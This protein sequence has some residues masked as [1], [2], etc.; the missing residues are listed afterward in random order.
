MLPVLRG[1]LPHTF[2]LKR[3][4]YRSDENLWAI[5]ECLLTRVGSVV[6]SLRGEGIHDLI[7]TKEID[8]L[9]DTIKFWKEFNFSDYD[10]ST[11]LQ[12][13]LRYLK[14]N[15]SIGIFIR[16]QNCFM[17]FKKLKE[18]DCLRLMTFRASLPNKYVM[19]QSGCM[20]ISYP[21]TVNIIPASELLLSKCF[22]RQL[23]SL[24]KETCDI[25]VIKTPK[26][27]ELQKEVREPSHPWMVSEFLVEILNPVQNPGEQLKEEVTITKKFRDQVNTGSGT[28]IPWRRSGVWT[29]VKVWL[30]MS[31]HEMASDKAEGKLLYKLVLLRFLTF[32]GEDYLHI[33]TNPEWDIT[34]E[35]LVKLARRAT[36]IQR[37]MTPPMKL[38]KLS[39]NVLE[40][41][42][43]T[44]SM[45][46]GKIS[47]AWQSTCDRA[48]LRLGMTP[49]TPATTELLE[50]CLH[51][52]PSVTEHL[53]KTQQLCSTFTSSFNGHISSFIVEVPSEI[54]LSA[55]LSC[56]ETLQR[57]K[58]FS[59][60]LQDPHLNRKSVWIYQVERFARQL[61]NTSGHPSKNIFDLLLQYSS[62]TVPLFEKE[63]QDPV[64][65]SRVILTLLLFIQYLDK[66]A[67]NNHPLLSEFATGINP[68]YFDRLL[69]PEQSEMEIL[70]RLK[71]YFVRRNGIG[72]RSWLENSDVRS[73]DFS[74]RYVNT[75]PT[76]QK[77]KHEMLDKMEHDIER[78]YAEVQAA[79]KEYKELG[80]KMQHELDGRTLHK[81]SCRRGQIPK[82]V[83][84]YIKILPEQDFQQNAVVF[85]LNIPETL[86]Y[87]RDSVVLFWEEILGQKLLQPE[88]SNLDHKWVEYEGVTQFRG[89]SVQRFAHLG[90]SQKAFGQT[91]YGKNIDVTGYDVRPENF[92]VG[93][94][95]QTTLFTCRHFQ[96]WKPE[97]ENMFTM[98]VASTG[99]KQGLYQPLQFALNLKRPSEN[100]VIASQY[101]CHHE[102][103]LREF[104]DF[105]SLRSGPSIQ[106][107]NLYIAISSK[108]LSLELEPVL[109][110][111]MQT[112]W[113]NG[114]IDQNIHL[115]FQEDDKFSLNFL[116]LVERV[117]ED[118]AS[119]WSKAMM[120][121]PLILIIVRILELNPNMNREARWRLQRFRIKLNSW[122][123]ALEDMLRREH[124]SDG[125]RER[126]LIS[127]LQVSVCL[128]FTFNVASKDLFEFVMENDDDVVTYLRTL[129]RLH[130]LIT[131]ENLHRNT[132]L[133]NFFQNLLRQARCTIPLNLKSHLHK[134]LI[135]SGGS[136]LHKFCG[137][138]W[139]GA[140]SFKEGNCWTQW[141]PLPN[142]SNHLFQTTQPDGH[143]LSVDILRGTFLVNG[144]PPS[145]LPEN[146]TG[147]PLFKSFFESNTFR[148]QRESSG[149]F[150]T[151]DRYHGLHYE[152]MKNATTLIIRQL[153]EHDGENHSSSSG[154]ME[155]VPRELFQGN[156][157]FDLI[158]NYTH[159]F[160]SDTKCIHFVTSKLY[161]DKEAKVD[162]KLVP[163]SPVRPSKFKLMKVRSSGEISQ[164]CLLSINST[165]F[166]L[167]AMEIS[168]LESHDF[169]HVTLNT[170]TDRLTINLW[171]H[172]LD[173]TINSSDGLLYSNKFPGYHIPDVNKKSRLGALI[174]LNNYLLMEKNIAEKLSDEVSRLVLVPHG[175]VVISSHEDKRHQNVTI[176]TNPRDSDN[177]GKLRQPTFFTFEV[178]TLLQRLKPCN[179]TSAWLYLA[180]LHGATSSPLPDPFTGLTGLESAMWIL[181]SGMVWSCSPY[182]QECLETLQFISGLSPKYNYYPDYLSGMQVTTWPAGLKK[183]SY[184]AYDGYYIIVEKLLEDSCR[185][186]D[187]YPEK[188]I[189]TAKLFE[190]RKELLNRSYLRHINMYHPVARLS[191]LFT[192]AP[193]HVM[194]PLPPLKFS[195]SVASLKMLAG[196]RH[197]MRPV[198]LPDLEKVSTL[199]LTAEAFKL[200]TREESDSILQDALPQWLEADFRPNWFLLYDLSLLSPAKCHHLTFLLGALL[201]SGKANMDQILN[202]HNCSVLEATPPSPMLETD[203]EKSFFPLDNLPKKDEIMAILEAA[204]PKFQWQRL[205]GTNLLDAERTHRKQ[206]AEE[207][208]MILHGI[209]KCWNNNET[210][211]RIISKKIVKL[212]VTYQSTW[213]HRCLPEI[214]EKFLFWAGNRKLTNF[215]NHLDLFLQKNLI[216]IPVSAHKGQTEDIVLICKPIMDVLSCWTENDYLPNDISLISKKYQ[217]ELLL[218]EQI[219]KTG[220]LPKSSLN[221]ETDKENCKKII[222]K[223][224]KILVEVL[225]GSGGPVSASVSTV[226]IFV[227]QAPIAL[228]RQYLE[229]LKDLQNHTESFKNPTGIVAI[230]VGTLAVL[231]SHLR[232]LERLI[233][234]Q[235]QPDLYS[236]ELTREMESF[237]D[238]QSWNRSL[239]PEW[240]LLEL[241][242]N[243]SIRPIQ[244]KMAHHMM[245]TNGPPGT[246]HVTQLNMGEGKTS[247]IVPMIVATL[248]KGVISRVTVLNSIFATNHNLLTFAIGGLINRRVYTIPCCRDLSSK[249]TPGFLEKIQNVYKEC[250]KF[251]GVVLTLPEYRLSFRLMSYNNFLQDNHETGQ[252]LYEIESW[253]RKHCR[254]VVDESDEVF[255]VKYQ[256]IYTTGKQLPLDGGAMRWRV[257]QKLLELLPDV[258]ER[259]FQ[260]FGEEVIEFQKSGG[261]S[262]PGK[263]PQFRILSEVCKEQFLGL[264]VDSVLE[265]KVDI[266]GLILSST[267]KFIV[268]EFLG[269]ETISK[270]KS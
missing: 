172:S 40:H 161:K 146:I 162:F 200:P 158:D 9:L 243:I 106:L 156:M 231:W 127:L 197:S 249:I 44:I 201:Y 267:E 82:S 71:K 171:R 43:S 50:A 141:K 45:L 209:L 69:L 262:T 119:N 208:S 266:F 260:S 183:N 223:Y 242:L 245:T 93:N 8:N 254:D 67:V 188:V 42:F 149:K 175:K 84:R 122:S 226:G 132:K 255:S 3:C 240:L 31:L 85:E 203:R 174:G 165:T 33:N 239:Y 228:L 252:K 1:L 191:N 215:V 27:G 23:V 199:I 94:G 104:H 54:A 108:S 123:V 147:D 46:H 168:P 137:T 52:I 135:I 211:P 181:H 143:H 17:W 20:Q 81:M 150:R 18:E 65:F 140:H 163:I 87:L 256:L 13:K 178:D 257:C 182:D 247:V 120:A 139:S 213:L 77:K 227:R 118:N 173:F 92:I 99:E 216:S 221:F 29:S 270:K 56:G 167:L 121:L 14:E 66:L 24:C 164:D 53:E 179:D 133:S 259:L 55:L 246:G 98:Q 80:A 102:L 152:F 210:D 21:E 75:C 187:L 229:N 83:W 22:S 57:K 129:H 62:I 206:I 5:E 74:V 97:S 222:R 251:S 220:K 248:G 153:R 218:T 176:F 230:V 128:V 194:A 258:G 185:L 269:N 68:N 145:H 195:R 193:Q 15:Q 51:E 60:L 136:A 233:C 110:L 232:R 26:S 73:E 151:V 235:G 101:T 224:S 76:L 100:F 131:R 64:H 190:S 88:R 38:N 103:S 237:Q 112:L 89:N 263:F 268:R 212:S 169:I 261:E 2:L 177:P 265:G 217:D 16:A 41:A 90:S 63:L 124:S 160:D 130:H 59:F 125:D 86:S 39:A 25:A 244:V 70:S 58:L 7:T 138:I 107:R 61:E 111:V 35:I 105:G 36:K 184:A 96:V 4:P 19:S 148:V 72:K 91:H 95:L 37:M 214:K 79:R 264:L 170:A 117:M 48:S 47:L 142:S 250:L 202:L 192:P 204:T 115:D 49:M 186:Q 155:L 28:Y 234:F 10:E 11:M 30:H 225:I 116:E 241:E 180:A 113:E 198:N 12:D 126:L 6:N 196:C 219:L 34:H 189:G 253:L 157:P 114:G 207:V 134:M 159:W 205:D 32:L 238:N 109:A 236:L 166:Q 78:K 154:F 144:Y